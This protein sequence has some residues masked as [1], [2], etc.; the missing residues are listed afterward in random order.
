MEETHDPQIHDC[1]GC[2]GNC[3]SGMFPPIHSTD[4]DTDT[5]ADQATGSCYTRSNA[6]PGCYQHACAHAPAERHI[7]GEWCAV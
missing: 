1:F 4:A 3:H 5:G 6:G 2:I 7:Y